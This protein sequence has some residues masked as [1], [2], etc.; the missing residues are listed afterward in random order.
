MKS[1]NNFLSTKSSCTCC[2]FLIF[3]LS[4]VCLQRLKGKQQPHKQQ[5]VFSPL[6]LQES[7]SAEINYN[8]QGRDEQY[9]IIPAKYGLL[10]DKTLLENTS[11]AAVHYSKSSFTGF[12]CKNIYFQHRFGVNYRRSSGINAQLSGTSL[13]LHVS[14]RFL[15]LIQVLNSL[16]APVDLQNGRPDIMF[17]LHVQLRPPSIKFVLHKTSRVWEKVHAA[18][19]SLCKASIY[20]IRGCD[21]KP[22][23]L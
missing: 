3:F 9:Q 2:F 13:K 8:D 15:R 22:F 11:C 5:K 17:L 21:S 6:T 7:V 20:G 18:Y 10:S 23:N 16:K 12:V 1:F 4:A 14:A 19:S